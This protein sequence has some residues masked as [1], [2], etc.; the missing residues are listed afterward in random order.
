MDKIKNKELFDTRPCCF[1]DLDPA[2]FEEIA[3]ASHDPKLIDFFYRFCEANV[4]P[5]TLRSA[6]TEEE[7]IELQNDFLSRSFNEFADITL[8]Y[9]Q[10]LNLY[11]SLNTNY[12]KY[13]KPFEL[14]FITSHMYDELG[15]PFQS[16]SSNV[17]N[18]YLETLSPLEETL[19]IRSFIEKSF[20]TSTDANLTTNY[21]FIS[22]N[23]GIQGNILK[24]SIDNVNKELEY[25]AIHG[26]NSQLKELTLPDA[27]QMAISK[28]LSC[29]DKF[30]PSVY[31]TNSLGPNNKPINIEVMPGQRIVLTE[32]P[33]LN[34]FGTEHSVEPIR[35]VLK[36]KLA[37]YDY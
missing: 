30:K 37:I 16:T 3:R 25:Y 24:N 29:Y 11:E 31:I 28:A 5:T 9:F 12:L 34:F 19:N 2:Q 13:L 4:L 15:T 1:P 32:N 10:K 35:Y 27:L 23:M 36:K 18:L 17:L 6:L 22:I 7:A 8:T 20:N 21:P 14:N 33:N 26:Y